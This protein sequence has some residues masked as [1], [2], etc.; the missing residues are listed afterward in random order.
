MRRYAALL[1]AILAAAVIGIHHHLPGVTADGVTYLQIARNLLLGEGLGWQALWTP[2]LHSLL[3]AAASLLTGGDLLSAAGVIAPLMFFCLVMAVYFLALETFDL[4]TALIAAV[5]AALFPHLQYIAFSAE[6][7]I[8]YAFFLTLSLLL[9]TRAVTRRSKVYA[10]AT[11]FCFAL[12]WMA[13]S[14][15]FVVMVLIIAAAV[16]MQGRCFYRSDIFRYGL[17]AV[18]LFMFSAAPYLFFLRNHYGSFVISPKSSYVMIWMKGKTYHDNDQGEKG[19]EELWGLT[20]DGQKY[21]WQEPKGISDLVGYLMAHPGKNLSVYLHNL[22]MEVPGRIPNN[23]G[24]ENYPQPYPIYFALAALLAIWVPWG[25]FAREK[26]A[27]LLSPFLILLLLPVF[28]EGWWK[29]LIPYLPL[30][31]ILAAKGCTA[32]SS[33]IAEKL[34][35]RG[36][37]RLGAI[38]LSVTTAAICV[39]FVLA[40]HPL[41]L[42]LPPQPAVAL[43]ADVDDRHLLADEARKAG[44]WG[45]RRFGPGKN[46]MSDGWTKMVYYLNGLWTEFPVADYQATLD[47]ARRKGVDYIVI[48]RV[49]DQTKIKPELA[50]GL[51]HEARYLSSTYPYAVDFYQVMPR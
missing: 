18:L 32:G 16:A 34:A 2:P 5:F 27:V 31:I 1:P 8:S 7:E 10:I 4:R 33:I 22:S 46:Y 30:L 29:Y 14:E 48:E 43:A 39:R 17:L 49:G 12:A 40:L 19:N 13:R 23:S 25:N 9:F 50:L 45:A 15:G 3:I 35:P 44:Q 41:S 6:A 21:R 36:P 37:V 20:P 24:M 26:R 38:L 47:F 28:T 11:G 42:G 51:M